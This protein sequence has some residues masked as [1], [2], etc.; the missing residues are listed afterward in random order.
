MTLCAYVGIIGPWFLMGNVRVILRW[1]VL[2]SFLLGAR[3]A[4]T[5]LLEVTSARTE[6]RHAG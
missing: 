3:L 5:L 1:V 2:A 4:R 6:R